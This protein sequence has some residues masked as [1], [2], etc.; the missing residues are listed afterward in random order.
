MIEYVEGVMEVQ[1]EGKNEWRGSA[2]SDKNCIYGR[3]ERNE[4]KEEEME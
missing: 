4:Y 1:T 3:N 2:D